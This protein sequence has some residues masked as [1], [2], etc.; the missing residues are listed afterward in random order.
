MNKSSI[1]NFSV[2][3]RKTLLY[4]TAKKAEYY[5]ITEKYIEPVTGESEDGIVIGDRVHIR[6][7]KKQREELVRMVLEKGYEQV[8]EEAACTWF[9]RFSTN[10]GSYSS[11]RST[12]CDFSFFHPVQHDDIW[13]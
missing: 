6:K 2:E 1:K 8:M 7:I 12:K 10:S 3:A 11:R 4:H 5:G 13:E 9:N